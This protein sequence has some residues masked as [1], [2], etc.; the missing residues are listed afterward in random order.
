VAEK[1]KGSTGESLGATQP[2]VLDCRVPRTTRPSPV[3]ARTEPTASSLGLAPSEPTASS[4]GL[5]PSIGVST[6]KRTMAR[7]NRTRTT[8]PA[9]TTRQLSSVVAQPPRMGPMAMP[10]PATPPMTA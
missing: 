1:P 3:A 5:A 7:M 2:Q 8:S 9:N 4:L 6:T 10:A